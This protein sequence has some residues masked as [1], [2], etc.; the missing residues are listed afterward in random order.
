MYFRI[1]GINGREEIIIEGSKNNVDWE[2]YD[3]FYKPGSLDLPPRV[4]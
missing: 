1:T 4:S 3:F 2:S